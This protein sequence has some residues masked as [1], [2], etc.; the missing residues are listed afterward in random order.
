MD[1]W[2][3]NLSRIVP[4]THL[5]QGLVTSWTNLGLYCLSSLLGKLKCVCVCVGGCCGPGCKARVCGQAGSSLGAS[6][7]GEVTLS[8]YVSVASNASLA[9]WGR[10]LVTILTAAL[11]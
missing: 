11:L 1:V 2:S 10:L 8:F 5:S 4:F 9:L 7:M 3:L 6:A